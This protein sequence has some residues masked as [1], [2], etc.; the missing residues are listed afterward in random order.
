[1]DLSTLDHEE[2]RSL[3]AEEARRKAS[4]DVS[5]ELRM[6]ENLQLWSDLLHELN[7]DLESQFMERK[8]DAQAFQ[9]ACF[10]AGPEGKREWFEYKAQY[11]SW[12]AGARRF[13]A[14][15]QQRIKENRQMMRDLQR[16]EDRQ[17]YR[18]AL[19]RVQEFLRTD[20]F[21]TYKGVPERD[22]LV[23]EIQAVLFSPRR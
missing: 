22:R 18:D 5:A 11:D 3:V 7:K 8:A 17:L 15:I 21:I 12:R 19:N 23:E 14:G 4:P 20:E 16:A 2:L 1:M 9:N 6:A 10:S 13:Q